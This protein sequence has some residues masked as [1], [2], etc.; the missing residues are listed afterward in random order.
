MRTSFLMTVL[1]M[2]ISGMLP[3]QEAKYELKSAIVEKESTAMGQTMEI[4]WY[5][6]DYGKTESIFTTIELPAALGGTKN[7]MVLSKGDDVVTI[8]LDENKGQRTPL[9]EA[10]INFSML[11]PEIMQSY[12][13]KETGTGTILDKPCSIYELQREEMGMKVDMKIWVWKG[14]QLKVEAATGGMT[15][16]SEVA[17]NIQENAPIPTDKL[18]IP[19]RV[20]IL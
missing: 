12:N 1:C 10:P 3:A 19:A 5:F 6:D 13:M 7:L 20:E 8:D 16:Y 18:T 14:L 17:T 2:C 4:T 9:P 11:T 15:V